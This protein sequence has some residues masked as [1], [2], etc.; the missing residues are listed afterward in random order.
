M[1]YIRRPGSHVRELRS[2]TDFYSLLFMLMYW[3]ENGRTRTIDSKPR[4]KV[5]LTRPNGRTA[6]EGEKTSDYKCL[7]ANI[8]I[9]H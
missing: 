7:I 6:N 9:Q 1:K 5:K 8:N 3:R 2:P 4:M